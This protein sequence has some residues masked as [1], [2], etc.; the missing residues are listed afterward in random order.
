LE[1]E[2]FH[3]STEEFAK[4]IQLVP[5]DYS[6]SFVSDTAQLLQCHQQGMDSF[7]LGLRV[8]GQQGTC[9]MSFF[10]LDK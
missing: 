5:S 9:G 4:Y 8:K 7:F 10:Y 2:I 3:A 1:Y 6:S